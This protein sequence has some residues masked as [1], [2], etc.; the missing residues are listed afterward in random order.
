MCLPSL[1]D[2][3]ERRRKKKRQRERE[4]KREREKKRAHPTPLRAS[5]RLGEQTRDDQVDKPEER[6][7]EF[8][9]GSLT[10]DTVAR[11]G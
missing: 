11:P 2:E 6:R 8:S 9:D 3:R 4:R 10:L 1:D 7:R 5:A